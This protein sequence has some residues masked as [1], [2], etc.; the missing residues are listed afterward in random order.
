LIRNVTNNIGSKVN[1][2]FKA[3]IFKEYAVKKKRAIYIARQKASVT[4][5]TNI[6][7]PMKKPWRLTRF[8]AE[9]SGDGTDVEAKRGILTHIPGAFIQTPE[10]NQKYQF[11]FRRRGPNRYPVYRPEQEDQDLTLQVGREIS[12]ETMHQ[13]ALRLID[14]EGQKTFQSQ[15]NY[16]LV[17]KEPIPLPGSEE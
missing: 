16:L 1:V 8:N 6:F 9:Q 7:K 12:S 10:M 5:L 2:L 4:D 17:G 14:A 11:V 3:E 13:K 15:L